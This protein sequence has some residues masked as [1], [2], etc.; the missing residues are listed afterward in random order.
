M[1]KPIN[2]VGVKSQLAKLMAT[3]NISV[4]H[5]AVASAAFDLE[6]R[7]LILPYWENITNSLYDLLVGHEVGH[8]LDSPDAKTLIDSYKEISPDPNLAKTFVNVVEDAR[9]EKLIKR[10]YPGL[11]RQFVAG[12]KEL[13]DRDFF[14]IKGKD[15]NQLGL[16]DRI[17][18]YF[19][20]GHVDASNIK[21]YDSEQPFIDRIERAE[22]YEEVVQICKE[23]YAYLKERN[24]IIEI[25]IAIQQSGGAPDDK[26][27][28]NEE[29][30]QSVSVPG[31]S[32][33]STTEKSDA[34]SD[35]DEGDDENSDVIPTP[36]LPD[37][38][39]ENSNGEEKKAASDDKGN[40]AEEKNKDEQKN[41]GGAITA[42]RFSPPVMSG[43]PNKVDPLTSITDAAFEAAK[44]SLAK[45]DR[46]NIPDYANIPSIDP[47][48][49]VISYKETHNLLRAWYKSMKSDG[50]L[51]NMAILRK[52]FNKFK[53]DNN[54]VIAYMLREFEAKKAA[55]EYARIM[56][57]RTGVLDT[58]KIHTYRYNDDLFRRISIKPGSKNH[59]MVMFIDLSGSMSDSM[60]GTI[61]QLMVLTMFCRRAQIAFEVYGFTDNVN[62][63]KIA[64]MVRKAGHDPSNPWY[65]IRGHVH[66]GSR[67]LNDVVLQPF[68]LKQYL[69]SHMSVQEYNEAML[70]LWYIRSSYSIRKW[71]NNDV[72]ESAHVDIPKEEGLG[73]TP[74]NECII[75]AREVIKNFRKKN[76]IQI[77]SAVFLTDGEG[78]SLSQKMTLRNQITSM[79]SPV[80]FTDRATGGQY[81]STTKSGGIDYGQSITLL[82]ALRDYTDARVIGFY[83]TNSYGMRTVVNRYGGDYMQMKALADKNKFVSVKAAGYDD[84]FIVKASDMEIKD[85]ELH[86]QKGKT[87]SSMT[88]QF[89][90]YLRAKAVNRVL[91][92]RFVTLIA[93]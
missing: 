79:R 58:N 31:S 11:R 64:D 75:A 21:F 32:K 40:D 46:W 87:V 53:Q 54:N 60:A 36:A 30:M 39:D 24:K 88:K 3:E 42:G 41:A 15:V 12:Y 78:A 91:L 22:K 70:H 86:V 34:M 38:P 68:A 74:L 83:L 61:E 50:E 71:T 25:E 29:K 92:S 4:Q 8:A 65:A 13:I 16:L 57:A 52:D 45:T 19:K 63:K 6:N 7:V 67:S 49:V 5:A 80:V 81:A 56:V 72:L 33:S 93:S 43:E 14:T 76:N 51:K 90:K 55:D 35:S 1:S 9:I 73:G 23:L 62:N 17:N 27:S 84:Y 59:G 44:K 82:N 18:L 89:T 48:E 28:D 10:R 77:V 47:D 20:L 69:S 66:I 2:I 37:L 26:K 85:E